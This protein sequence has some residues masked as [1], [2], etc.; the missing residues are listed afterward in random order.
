MSEEA[1]MRFIEICVAA[2]IFDLCVTG[3]EPLLNFPATRILVER[4]IAEGICVSLNT[5]LTLVNNKSAA[6]IAAQGVSV[7]SSLLGPNSAVHDA[8]TGVPGSFDRTI[9]GFRLCRDAGIVPSLNMVVSRKNR[10][11]VRATGALIAS[12]G[13]TFF[14][15]TSAVQ[16]CNCADFSELE[17]TPAENTCV[18]NDLLSVRDEKKLKVD[19]LTST[20]LCG[21]YSVH[22]PLQ[23][24][25]RACTAGVMQATVSCDGGVRPCPH[26]DTSYGNIFEESL[27]DIWSRMDDWT[28]KDRLPQSCIDCS[29]LLC[30]GGGCRMLAKMKTGDFSA[31]DPR[32][33]LEAIPE[34]RERLVQSVPAPIELSEAFKVLPYKV[35]RES[36][37]SIVAGGKNF[38]A[39]LFLSTEA[40]ALLE[41]L[42]PGQIY[43]VV[44]VPQL[45]SNFLSGLVER[46]VIGFLPMSTGEEERKVA[47]RG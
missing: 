37:G 17:L 3:G 23:F 27:E 5:N 15:A 30:C 47:E 12:E 34:M 22:D 24:A 40:T 41:S 14:S 31:P 39:K 8:I 29:L 11:Y 10:D 45:D 25:K 28:S 26:S 20:P 7:L 19:T 2:K 36:F 21:L 9:R 42:H 44:D 35:R 43:R 18:L 46:G 13:G 6:W 16:P 33:Y 1:A 4:A 38:Q 32:V